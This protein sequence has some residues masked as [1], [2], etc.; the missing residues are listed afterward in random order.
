VTSSTSKVIFQLAKAPD[1]RFPDVE[2]AGPEGLLA[3]GGDLDTG[4]ILAAYRH[5]I[6]PWYSEDQPI[7]W[8][9]PDPRAVL[10]PENLKISRSLKKTL[11]KKI[12]RVT[13]DQRFADV[14]QACADIRR[15]E[16]DTGTWITPDMMNAYSK[17]HELGYAHSVEVWHEDKLVGGLYGIALGKAFFGE[18]MFS[19]MTDASKTGFCYLVRQLEKW[20]FRFIDC[21][22]ES[23]HLASLG[24]K[25]IP[26]KQFIEMLKETLKFEDQASHWVADLEEVL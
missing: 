12:F 25:P 16:E 2:Y 14:I 8:W 19:R 18:S 20:G 26:R 9:S 11:R 17:L 10:L 6:F 24:A 15:G 4:R 13:L 22:V 1:Y 5:G 7:L 21:Q 23:A 3:V